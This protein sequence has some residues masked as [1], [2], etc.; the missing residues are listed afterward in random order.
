MKIQNV[1]DAS[2]GNTEKYWLAMIWALF[3]V[4]EAHTSAGGYG[5]V[6]SVE[7]LEVLISPENSRIGIRG[8]PIQ[9]DTA[10]DIIKIERSRVSPLF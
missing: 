4:N 1:T 7:E 10:T 6:P 2:L 5:Y 8:T 9:I 3:C